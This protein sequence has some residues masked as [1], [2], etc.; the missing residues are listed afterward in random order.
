LPSPLPPLPLAP[1]SICAVCR[2]RGAYN[3]RVVTTTSIL[4]DVTIA[5]TVA[6]FLSSCKTLATLGVGA[7][8]LL[9][10]FVAPTIPIVTLIVYTHFANKTNM[11]L[12]GK[13]GWTNLV[14]ITFRGQL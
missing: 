12:N 10:V 3:H 5:F 14:L 7:P 9:P 8:M 6:A 2:P 11:P 4:A 13:E 1:A